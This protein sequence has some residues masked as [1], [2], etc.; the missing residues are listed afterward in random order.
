MPN[1]VSNKLGR[2]GLTVTNIALGTSPLGSSP[3]LYG[4]AV[5][6]ER[7]HDTIRAFFSGP[8]NFA[9]TS[10]LLLLLRDENNYGQGRSERRLARLFVN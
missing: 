8:L 3:N 5:D 10:K 6:E 9:D 7:A 2:T 1:I 4:Y